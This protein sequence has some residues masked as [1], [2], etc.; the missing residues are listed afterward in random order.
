MKRKL[1]T[2]L[3]LMSAMVFAADYVQFT[4][5][6]FN[7]YNTYQDWD[8]AQMITLN[9][10]KGSSVYLSIY[11]RSW[12]ENLPDLGDQTYAAGYDMSANSYGYVYAERDEQ[13]NVR[14]VGPV[15]YANGDTKDVTVK[16]PTGPQTQTLTGYYLDTFDKDAEIF[17]VMTP[18]G[19]DTTVNSF[20]PVNDPDNEPNYISILKSRQINTYDLLGQT[21][22]NFGTVDGVAHEFI[23]GYEASATPPESSGQPLPGVLTSAL[24]GLCATGIA[25]RR[26]KNARK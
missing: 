12:Y 4:E 9:V 19:Y 1:L 22:V 2:L 25:A 24:I 3:L 7:L 20:S 5:S 17:L 6:D 16:N 18:N 14:P 15:H 23:I 8:Y 13:G 10:S 11:T 26:R 21:R